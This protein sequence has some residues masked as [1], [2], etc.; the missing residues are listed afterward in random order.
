MKDGALGAGGDKEVVRGEGIVG[1]LPGIERYLKDMDQ[2]D[3]ESVGV[4]SV[5]V[6]RFRR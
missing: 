6:D 3:E 1:L 5:S 2:S 4:K